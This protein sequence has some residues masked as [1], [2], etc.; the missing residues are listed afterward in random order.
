VVGTSL[1]VA[2]ANTLPS[3]ARAR[4]GKVIVCNM[5]EVCACAVAKR[6]GGSAARLM[7]AGDRAERRGAEETG[8]D[9]VCQLSLVSLLTYIFFWCKYFFGVV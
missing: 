4:F 2:P 8:L 1:R 9:G 7:R 3:I 5:D 6:G